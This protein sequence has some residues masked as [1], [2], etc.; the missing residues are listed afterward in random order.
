MIVCATGDIY[1]AMDRL[2]AP[3]L[4]FALSVIGAGPDL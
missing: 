2:R 4:V 3:A 1:G